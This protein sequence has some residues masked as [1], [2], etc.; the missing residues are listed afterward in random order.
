MFAVNFVGTS[1]NGTVQLI[2]VIINL[3]CVGVVRM[4]DQWPFNKLYLLLVPT[5]AL[6]LLRQIR[7]YNVLKMIVVLK[8]NVL[9]M[10]VFYFL[11]KLILF[12]L[13]FFFFF[14]IES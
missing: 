11:L 6:Q 3:A 2:A 1:L 7:T 8:E 13:I 5:R 4:F 10:I 14:C 9:K 12:D